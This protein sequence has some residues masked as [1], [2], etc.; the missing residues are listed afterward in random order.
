M[1]VGHMAELGERVRHAI[2]QVPSSHRDLA[3]SIGMDPTKLSKSLAGVRRFRVEELVA[4]ADEA[5]VSIDWILHGTGPTP[6]NAEP[7]RRRGTNGRTTRRV[8]ILESAWRLVAHRG[9]HNVRIADI[10]EACGTS[11]AAIHYYF[12]GKQDVMQQA[13][14]HCAEAAFTR[15]SHELAEVPDARDRLLRLIELLLPTP[16]QVRDE[17]MIWLQVSS[18]S[19]LNPDLRPVHNDFSRRWRETVADVVRLGQEQDV[20]GDG[21]PERTA[22]VFMSIADGLAVRVLTGTPG[23]SVESMREH[24]LA[25]SRQHIL[26]PTETA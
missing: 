18:V 21:D 23:S 25:L 3:D 13:L 15:Q 20:F 26:L 5:R 19:A 4:I 8:E 7:R 16:G 24:L 1:Y 17:W 10:A 2:D 9:L 14:L 6:H 22:V 12:P 11:S